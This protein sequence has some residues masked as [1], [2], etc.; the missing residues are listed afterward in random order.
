MAI[1]NWVYGAK[2]PD[3]EQEV[4]NI[5]FAAHCYRNALC[6]IELDRRAR[7]YD[8]LREL[9]PAYLQAE[10]AVT[11]CKAELEAVRAEIQEERVK[12]K[13]K[14][15]KGIK[16]LTQQVKEILARL[17]ALDAT[18]VEA[19]H[20]SYTTPNVMVAMAANEAQYKVEVKQARTDSGLH[21]GTEGF[22]K[23]SCKPFKAKA[24][25]KFKRYEGEGQ[26]CIPFATPGL[27]CAD[28]ERYNTIF[29]LGEYIDR[30][31]RYC[32]IRVDSNNRKPVFAKVPIVFHRPLP[33]GKIKRAF[34]ERRKLANSVKWSIRLCIDVD[35]EP[36]R[37]RDGEVAIH[38]GWRVEPNGLRA[39]TWLGS[40]G[41]RGTLVLSN[42][43]CADYTRLDT[44]QS[45]RTLAFNEMIAWLRTWAKD[46]DVPEWFKEIRSYLHTWKSQAKLAKLYWQWSEDRFDGDEEIF[47]MLNDWRKK[48]KHQWQHERRL[49][50]RIAR[51]R[52]DLYHNF[53]KK[54][55]DRYGVAI[56]APIATKKLTEKSSPED[57]ERDNTQA[58]RHA[59][60]V[61]VSELTG[62]IKER[63][64]L[65]CVEVDCKNITRQCCNCGVINV[66]ELNLETRRKIQCQG[67]GTTYDVDNNAATVTLMRG[68]A[69]LGDGALAKLVVKQEEKEAKRIAKQNR[70][71]IGRNAYYAAKREAK[72]LQSG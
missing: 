52:K 36:D 43:H 69:S 4:S 17:K 18:R 12:Q 67:C 60:W 28:A 32:Y 38:T 40:D 68:Q 34:L 26:V 35:Q 9:A 53:T 62:F 64:P 42:E 6:K 39:C 24:P 46:Q 20:N 70:M 15:P 7:L 66:G 55:A 63:F 65:H 19:K 48:D 1:K 51:R 31:R 57:L 23:E 33:A 29:Y 47:S 8:I 72:A 2:T 44:V 11:V 14:T 27:D 71:T 10:E 16:H 21:Y 3:I 22:I 41:E 50:K 25:P 45:D 37:C 58:N 30:R 56:I 13:T 59:K 54:L 49:A 61:A 5:I